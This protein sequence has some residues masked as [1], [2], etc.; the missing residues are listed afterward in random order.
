MVVL[1]ENMHCLPEKRYNSR[2]VAVC[3]C[4]PLKLQVTSMYVKDGNRLKPQFCILT[5]HKSRQRR[6]RHYTLIPNNKGL[7]AALAGSRES[8]PGLSRGRRQFNY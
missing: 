2:L 8:E 6:Y 1:H 7:S 5:L 4:P 3:H